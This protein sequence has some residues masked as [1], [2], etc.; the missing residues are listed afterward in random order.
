MPPHN[1][2]EAKKSGRE[3]AA[4]GGT[5][6]FGVQVASQSFPSPILLKPGF[7]SLQAISGSSGPKNVLGR[8]SSVCGS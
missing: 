4:T 8:G 1:H 6:K 3:T 7:L 2:Y 5:T